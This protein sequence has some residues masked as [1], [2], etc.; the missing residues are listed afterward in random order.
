MLGWKIALVQLDFVALEACLGLIFANP[1]VCY[2]K[3]W[4]GAILCDFVRLGLD[5]FGFG[6]GV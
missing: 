4:K 5:L 6:C 3:Y 2:F 1:F